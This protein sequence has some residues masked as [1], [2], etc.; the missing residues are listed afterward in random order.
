M[1]P[2]GLRRLF[3]A[4]MGHGE[5]A[6]DGAGEVLPVRQAHPFAQG[7]AGTRTVNAGRCGL[8]SHRTAFGASPQA[9][10]HLMGRDGL[11]DRPRTQR[12]TAG[13]AAARPQAYP[14]VGGGA[15]PLA[16]IGAATMGGARR[17]RDAAGRV[18]RGR[19][20]GR[21]RPIRRSTD[22]QRRPAR[23]V[24][25]SAG[26]TPGHERGGDDAGSAGDGARKGDGCGASARGAGA[27]PDAGRTDR[28]RLTTGRDQFTAGGRHAGAA[29]LEGW[30]E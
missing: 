29:R 13:V 10:E 25:G 4:F 14:A 12:P 22:A 3:A 6:G 8:C 2:K 26:G 16:G 9:R 17:R 24:S 5:G 15:C 20:D 7:E 11:P 19:T 23:S 27:A 28:G 30:E 18:G 21:T 1:P